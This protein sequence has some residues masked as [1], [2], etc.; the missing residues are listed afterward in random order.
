MPRVIGRITYTWHCSNS[1]RCCGGEWL[2]QISPKLLSNSVRGF[3]LR[4][5]KQSIPPTHVIRFWRRLYYCW[6]YY[7]CRY[8]SNHADG[9]SKQRFGWMDIGNLGVRWMF[10]TRWSIVLRWTCNDRYARWRWVCLYGQSLWQ[11]DGEFFRLG[12]ILDHPSW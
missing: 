8:L 6:H 9:C 4:V 5:R 7:W 1:H 10:S 2:E 12:R 3:I 11:R